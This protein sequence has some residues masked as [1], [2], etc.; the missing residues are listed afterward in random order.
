MT[1]AVGRTVDAD[2]MPP[3]GDVLD[4]MR[5]IWAMDHALERTSKRMEASIGLTGPQRLVLRIVGRF[6]G[7]SAGRLAEIL[8][9]HPSTLTGVLQRLERQELIRR[10]ADS[11]DR[12]RSL[13]GT[14]AKGRALD[15][16]TEGTV[17]AAVRSALRHFPPDVLSAA[18]EVLRALTL[19]LNPPPDKESARSKQRSRRPRGRR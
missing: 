8:H 18:R 6:P 4:F 10:R 16:E 13:I 17:E 19:A 11:R 3:L 2:P 7:I 5:L 15:V 9:L 14:T 12:R 1:R